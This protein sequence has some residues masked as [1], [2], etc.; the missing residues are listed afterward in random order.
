MPRHLTRLF[1]GV[2]VALSLVSCGHPDHTFGDSPGT[3]L[4]VHGV[5]IRYA[6]LA[7]PAG[8]DGWQPGSD[9]PLYVRFVNTTQ[10][11]R[12]LVGAS[13]PVAEAVSIVG[14]SYPLDLP[15]ERLVELGRDGT[16]L[17]LKNINRRIRGAELVPVT[18]SFGNGVTAPMQVEPVVPD[19]DG[20]ATPPT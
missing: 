5:A 16:H 17:M 4:D 20:A 3:N 12:Q 19:L 15:A 13:T 7:P 14:G 18:L 2:A 8:P 11:P 9:V 1:A 6:H 10:E